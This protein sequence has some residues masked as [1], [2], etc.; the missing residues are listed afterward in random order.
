M[1]RFIR[2]L[3]AV[4]REYM[5][6]LTNGAWKERKRVMPPSPIQSRFWTLPT[7]V[8][9]DY[10]DPTFYNRLHPK[11]QSKL[12]RSM[13]AFA[14]DLDIDSMLLAK[15]EYAL[16]SDVDFLLKY[17]TSVLSQYDDPA[18]FMEGQR[19]A[20]DDGDMENEEEFDSHDDMQDV[21]EDEDIAVSEPPEELRL[22]Q[23]GL[24]NLVNSH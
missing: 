6:D 12:L 21:D 13:I 8:P 16:T 18:E 20:D 9:I 7:D 1:E 3:D 15:G 23:E 22:K 2:V 11:I 19:N 24:A 4:R 10:F 17:G 5:M 14:P